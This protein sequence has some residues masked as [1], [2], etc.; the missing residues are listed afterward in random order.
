MEDVIRDCRAED[1]KEET[2]MCVR[3]ACN[4]F[5]ARAIFDREDA[6]CN[7]LASIGT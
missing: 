6:L 5:R 3:R 1:A 4:V 2:Y 7:H